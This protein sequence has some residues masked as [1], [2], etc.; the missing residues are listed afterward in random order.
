M[1]GL[2]HALGLAAKS[3]PLSDFRPVNPFLDGIGG[4]DPAI[5]LHEAEIL[6]FDECTERFL[7]RAQA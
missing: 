2:C 3:L 1:K 7:F 4:F 6:A 5:C